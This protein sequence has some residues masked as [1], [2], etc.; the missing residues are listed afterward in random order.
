[1]LG[2]KTRLLITHYTFRVL[3]N[4]IFFFAHTENEIIQIILLRK[5]DGV[6]FRRKQVQILNKE[7]YNI[8]RKWKRS[9]WNMVRRRSKRKATVLE[10]LTK[11]HGGLRRSKRKLALKKDETK[12][13]GDDYGILPSDWSHVGKNLTLLATPLFSEVS[14]LSIWVWRTSGFLITPFANLLLSR[15][16][17]M[18]CSRISYSRKVSNDV[19]RNKEPILSVISTAVPPL[20][21]MFSSLV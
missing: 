5:V 8:L 3:V 16:S 6:G 15:T 17:L 10:G 20:L 2:Y 21:F 4:N 1:M 18:Q 19:N 9:G 11:A 14:P 13:Y 12:I 7:E